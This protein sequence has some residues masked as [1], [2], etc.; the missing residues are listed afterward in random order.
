MKNSPSHWKLR[1]NKNQTSS[2]L[3]LR[4]NSNTEKS[5]IW[6]PICLAPN[7]HYVHQTK[8]PSEDGERGERGGGDRSANESKANPTPNFTAG[9]HRACG[10]VKKQWEPCIPFAHK[11]FIHSLSS[12]QHREAPGSW[13]KMKCETRGWQ[14]AGGACHARPQRGCS[15]WL[16][17]QSIWPLPPLP[18]SSLWISP[19]HPFS[20]SCL[21]SPLYLPICCLLRSWSRDSDPPCDDSHISP[22]FLLTLVLLAPHPSPLQSTLWLFLGIGVY[23]VPLIFRGTRETTGKSAVSLSLFTPLCV[24]SSTSFVLCFLFPCLFFYC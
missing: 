1:R 22:D 14:K 21:C 10:K 16:F 20:R 11:P 5:M 7:T 8:L 15:P 24:A 18:L 12:E 4:T 2:G 13:R 19:P 17:S 3:C 6:I 23:L 9:G